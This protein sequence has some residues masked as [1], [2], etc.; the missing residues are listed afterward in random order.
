V[1]GRW[2][3][4]YAFDVEILSPDELGLIMKQYISE[5]AKQYP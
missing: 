2:L 3:L 4:D 1:L 5:M